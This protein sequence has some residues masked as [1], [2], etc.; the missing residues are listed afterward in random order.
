MCRWQVCP[1]H[2]P[3]PPPTRLGLRS[4]SPGVPGGRGPTGRDLRA[5]VDRLLEENQKLKAREAPLVARIA[6]LEEVRGPNPSNPPPQ[7]CGGN[8]GVQIP[9]ICSEAPHAICAVMDRCWIIRA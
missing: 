7:T 5:Q 2:P 4:L 8:T 1:D 9:S 6:E 3:P